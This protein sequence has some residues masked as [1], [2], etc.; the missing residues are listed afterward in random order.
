MSETNLNSA[1]HPLRVMFVTSCMDVGGAEVLLAALVRKMDRSRILPELCCLKH[2][3]PLG[4]ELVAEIP[5]YSRLLK[6]K[7]DV[8]V[9]NRLARLMQDRNIDAVVTVGTGGDKMFWGRLAARKAKVPVILSALHSTGLPDRV[10][11]PNRL[12]TSQTDGF[13]AVA[14]LHAKYI[15]DHEGC[16]ADRVHVIP[17]GVDVDRF[18]RR[19]ESPELR[20]SI[21][22]PP[23]SPLVG[24]VAN[25]RPEKNHEL[26]LDVASHVRQENP[27]AHFLI[28]GDGLRRPELES[29]ASQLEL[30]DRVHF[31]GARTDTPELMSLLDVFLLTSQMEANPV[32]ILEAMASETPVVATRVGSIPETI[33]DGTTGFLADAGDAV[34][35]SKHVHRLLQDSDLAERTGWL[36][37]QRVQS[38]YSI[39][40]MVDGYEAL[41]WSTYRSKT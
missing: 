16:P 13:I 9:R 3:G 2:P 36:A 33:V 21:G 34:G 31:L 40:R 23:D 17:N 1:A 32:T 10:E 22:V 5:V 29:L 35:L 8:S 30:Q 12:L 41:L 7:F 14:E 25:L 37:R 20:R 38:N 19:P 4:E 15:T 39:D 11:W 6:H 24:I 26:F 18:H 28:V 27:D